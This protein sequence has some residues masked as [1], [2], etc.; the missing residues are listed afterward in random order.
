MISKVDT[1]LVEC[2]GSLAPASVRIEVRAFEG[3]KSVISL[4]GNK[5]RKK[6]TYG[7]WLEMRS[8]LGSTDSSEGRS[9]LHCGSLIAFPGPSGIG[10][11]ERGKEAAPRL[12]DCELEFCKGAPSRL[13]VVVRGAVEP[14][15]VLDALLL[16]H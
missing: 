6:S 10:V 1:L 11:S 15:T 12:V 2:P 13:E 16:S 7:G 3:T 5:E 14:E 9:T 8:A 4:T